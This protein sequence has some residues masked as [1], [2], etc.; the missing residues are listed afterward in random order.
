MIS[1]ELGI[2]ELR[3]TPLGTGLRNR[4]RFEFITVFYVYSGV[5]F[6]SVAGVVRGKVQL[7]VQVFRVVCNP[8][9]GVSRGMARTSAAILLEK[10]FFK[11]FP[12]PGIR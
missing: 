7:D 4:K 1:S 8:T 5:V 3:F 10:R 9:V 2:N 12:F 6:V 11:F